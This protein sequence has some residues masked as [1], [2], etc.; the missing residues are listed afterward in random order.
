MKDAEINIQLKLRLNFV[1][2]KARPIPSHFQETFKN[3]LEKMKKIRNI[4]KGTQ[5]DE[6]FCFPNIESAKNK[7]NKIA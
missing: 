1:E 3:D 2:L 5:V 6:D 7:N 4:N